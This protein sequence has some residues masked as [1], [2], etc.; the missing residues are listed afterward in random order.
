MADVATPSGAAMFDAGNTDKKKVERLEKPEK[1]DEATYKA[2]L[3]KAEKELAVALEKLN[4]VKAKL[5]VGGSNKDSPHAKAKAEVLSQLKEIQ[6][7]QGEGKAGRGQVLDKIKKLDDSMRADQ[8]ALKTARGRLPY[9]S[10]EDV[11]REIERLD[12]QV[13]SGMMKLV[14]EKKALAEISSLRKLRKQFA[15]LDETQKSIDNK[16]AEIKKLRDST[17]DPESKAL[18]EK[19]N[20]LQT[21]LDGYKAKE[22]ETYKNIKGLRDER[23][24][25]HNEQQEKWAAV[26]KLKDDYYNANRAVQKWEYEARQK[27]RERKENEYKT[28]LKEKKKER[29]QQMLAEASEK[30]YL[31]EIRR[32]QSL[33]QFFDPTFK[34][35]KAPLLAPSGLQASAQ[36]KVDDSGLK[37]TK[38]VKKD[39]EDYF[40]GTGG[41][42]KGKK[43]KKN[44]AVEDAAPVAAKFSCPPSVME[45]C[46]SMGIEPPMSAADVPGVLEK[47]K[48]KLEHWK[49]D[50]ETQTQKNIEK[51]K[52]ELEKLEAEEAE[53]PAAT[54]APA[55]AKSHGE[56]KATAGVDDGGSVANEVEL[57]KEAV[58]D[59]VADLK[60][61]SIE[62]N[63]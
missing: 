35:E 24:K 54:S 41:K 23:T 19:Y 49:S 50:Q 20:K 16:K 11:D 34:Q 21:E 47:V 25:Y 17:N 13:N 10:L 14:D 7:Q 27:Q 6:K 61:A 55:K 30:A 18:S 44:V 26:K 39:E 57:I 40:A 51:A 46:S 22:D 12:K 28:A 45:D 52:K 4:A 62:D 38:I 8:T 9:K 53:T 15:G 60:G 63:A 3:A 56:T 36:R 5:D 59:V 37:G 48:A 1:P 31:D 58:A 2:S 43:N 33:L 32:A 42:K 29:A